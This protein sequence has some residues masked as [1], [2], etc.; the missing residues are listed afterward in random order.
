MIKINNHTLPTPNSLSIPQFDVDSSDTTRNE[1]GYLQ[2]DRVRQGIYKIELGWQNIKSSQANEILNL[3]KPSSVNVTFPSPNG[4]VTKKMYAGDRS[5]ELSKY[6]NKSDV[7]W[8]VSF[9]LIE[10]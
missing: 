9:N 7:R 5:V 10:Y 2:R 6:F 1:A 4:N 3:I 8:N